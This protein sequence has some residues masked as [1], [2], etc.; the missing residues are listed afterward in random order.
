MK[1]E[2]IILN[3]EEY[4]I[5]PINKGYYINK[6]GKIYSCYSQKF[7]KWA[8]DKDGYPRVD[9]YVNGKQKHFKVHKLVWITWM[10][11]LNKGEQLNHLDDNKTNPSLNN[12]YIGT[13]KENIQDCVTNEHRVG[14]VWSLCIYDIEVN[15][16][17]TFC[18]AKKFIEYS[19]HSCNSGSITKMMKKNWFKK[20]FKIIYYKQ[21]EN[22]TTMADECKP[23][24]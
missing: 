14:N 19:G 16:I 15:Q 13:Q 4:K 2:I 20:R 22:V 6:T 1:K 24:E 7:L 8:I 10:G 11:P 12:L 5:C 21:I 9:L 17:L 18:P 23:V 3:Q